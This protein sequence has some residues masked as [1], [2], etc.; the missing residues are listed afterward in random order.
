MAFGLSNAPA[1]IKSY[2]DNCL[3]PF[4]V[5]FAVCYLDDILIYSTDKEEHEEQ[6]PTVLERLGEFALYSKA[7]KCCF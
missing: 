1:T 6:A 2:I 7:K 3:R 5:N 4:I